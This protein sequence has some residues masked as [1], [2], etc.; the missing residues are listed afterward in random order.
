METLEEEELSFYRELT[1]KF[2]K[3]Q[4]LSPLDL[5]SALTFL[6][7]K[8]R[9]LIPDDKPIPIERSAESREPWKKGDRND[10]PERS[11][12]ARG[13]DDSGIQYRIEVGRNDGVAPK[14]IVGAI[15]NEAGIPGKSI[16]HIKL[17]DSFSTVS[18]P[19][20]LPKQAMNR[21][22]KT[23]IMGKPIQIRAAADGGAKPAAP[24]KP[25]KKAAY[26]KK[27]E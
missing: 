19:A 25:R 20:D 21:L 1:Q 6:V 8:E 24:A 4:G 9:P 12:R 10:R 27:G 11:P 13:F 22:Q 5:A 3:E 17:F 14:D 26:P 2:A 23:F 18:L 15:A 16:G 7:Q